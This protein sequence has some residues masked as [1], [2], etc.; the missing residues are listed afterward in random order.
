MV[1]FFDSLC[2]R[3]LS[4]AFL[5]RSHLFKDHYPSDDD[6]CIPEASSRFRNDAEGGS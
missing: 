4:G 6:Q 5:Q 2:A 1:R 3:R